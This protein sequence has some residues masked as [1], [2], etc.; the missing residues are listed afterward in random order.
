MITK[1]IEFISDNVDEHGDIVAFENLKQKFLLEEHTDF[2]DNFGSTEPLP[3]K[4]KEITNSQAQTK[5]I[6]TLLTKLCKAEKAQGPYQILR[7]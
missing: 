3:T 7:G 1:S 4:L 6:D 2:L 5:N